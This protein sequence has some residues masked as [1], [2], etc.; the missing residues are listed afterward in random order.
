VR[1]PAIT[2]CARNPLDLPAVEIAGKRRGPHRSAGRRGAQKEDRRNLN[3][4]DDGGSRNPF[5]DIG[6]R[7]AAK[8]ESGEHPGDN[9][10][11]P[12]PKSASLRTTEPAPPA[13][14]AAGHKTTNASAGMSINQDQNSEMLA[15]KCG[16]GPQRIR[17][18]PYFPSNDNKEIIDSA[19][20]G[21]AAQPNCHSPDRPAAEVRVVWEGRPVS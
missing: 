15:E 20:G 11:R 14:A 7:G 12:A 17:Y 10:H 16:D 19:R 1:L 2:P 18:R 5:A 13:S 4:R 3:N 8:G 21:C 6:V 9:N